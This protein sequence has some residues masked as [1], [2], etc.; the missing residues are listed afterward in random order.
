[1]NAQTYTMALTNRPNSFRAA[2][3]FVWV[4][5]CLLCSSSHAAYR[6]QTTGYAN[7]VT[8]GA[9]QQI[10]L[11]ATSSCTPRV[12]PSRHEYNFR[13]VM[14]FT[15]GLLALLTFIFGLFNVATYISFTTGFI[16]HGI[17]VPFIYGSLVFSL[18]S[19]F[20]GSNRQTALSD[21]GVSLALIHLLALGLL[22]GGSD[23]IN[24]IAGKRR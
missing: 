8:T 16:M 22:F 7:T 10:N 17:G 13:D 12:K 18:L 2:I 11:P 3:F 23:L 5:C 15:F 9:V 21:K 1:M 20:L 19:I 14:V 6:M 24:K 4:F